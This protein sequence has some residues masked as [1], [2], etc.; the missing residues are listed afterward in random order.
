MKGLALPYR[1]QTSLNLL[2][3]RG[4]YLGFLLS[5]LL[6]LLVLLVI[7]DL[8]EKIVPP[9]V[10]G[11]AAGL[12]GLASLMLG[13]S[14]G[15]RIFEKQNED[16]LAQTF[17][18]VF[19]LRYAYAAFPVLIG[20]VGFF[21]TGGE[22]WVFLVGFSFSLPGLIL[23][24]PTRSEIGRWEMRLRAQGSRQSLYQALMS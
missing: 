1:R 16:D 3:L 24:A 17:R 9:E 20:F 22:V 13:R 12:C 4:I 5:H 21:L 2:H 18:G 14:I 23:M 6:F 15:N 19:F 8:G 10:A 7:P 11:S